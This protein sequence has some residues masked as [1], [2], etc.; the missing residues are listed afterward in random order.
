MLLFICEECVKFNLEDAGRF[1]LDSIFFQ[2]GFSHAKMTVEL[3]SWDSSSGAV[4]GGTDF[5]H[6]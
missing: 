2:I 6:P 3:S 4:G 5:P 1:V